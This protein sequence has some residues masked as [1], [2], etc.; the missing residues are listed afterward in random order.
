M[1]YNKYYFPLFNIS[2]ISI[3]KENIWEK[4]KGNFEKER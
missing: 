1:Y 3:Q 2:G 4:Y